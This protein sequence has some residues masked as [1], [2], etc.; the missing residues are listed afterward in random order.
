MSGYRPWWLVAFLTLAASESP[1]ADGF[2]AEALGKPIISPDLGV[3]EVRLF[4]E[5]RVEL[6]D[7]AKLKRE[8]I[9]AL[10]AISLRHPRNFELFDERRKSIDLGA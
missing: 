4:A 9:L 5:R 3:A 7:L 10:G 6:V 8:K 2:V 1:G